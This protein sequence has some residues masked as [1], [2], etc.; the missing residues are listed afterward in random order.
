[1]RAFKVKTGEPQY[2][3]SIVSHPEK[4]TK[5][6]QSQTFCDPLRKFLQEEK[7]AEKKNGPLDLIWAIL[8]VA[9]GT[10][11]LI[12]IPEKIAQIAEI[13][14]LS[15]GIFFIRLCFYLMAILLIGG[16]VLKVKKYLNTGEK[17]KGSES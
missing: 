13:P 15:G 2:F 7:M 4:K 8:L 17:K 11:V 16:G 5:P 10:G 3:C 14:S 6:L 1:M 9:A 12:K